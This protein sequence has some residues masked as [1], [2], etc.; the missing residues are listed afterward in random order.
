M[1]KKGNF[2]NSMVSGRIK[3]LGELSKV[4]LMKI[5]KSQI[6]SSWFNVLFTTVVCLVVLL[7]FYMIT[8][9]SNFEND[10]LFFEKQFL[11]VRKDDLNRE[12]SNRIDEINFIIASI[13]TTLDQENQRKI[14]DLEITIKELEHQYANKLNREDFLSMVID[15]IGKHGEHDSD[16]MYFAI[17]MDGTAYL[18]D[19]NKSII[20]S[21]VLDIKDINGK[22]FIQDMI[23]IV[24]TDGEGYLSYY[25]PKEDGDEAFRKSSYFKYIESLDAFIGT[26][27]YYDEIEKLAQEKVYERFQNYY[28]GKQEYIFVVNYDGI[29]KVFGNREIVGKDVSK[30][31]DSGGEYLHDM[32]MEIVRKE[33][34]GYS[35]YTYYERFNNIDKSKKIA[36]VEGLDQW[37]VYIGMGFYLNE[38]YDELELFITEKR[39]ELISNVLVFVGAFIII[40]GIMAF[41]IVRSIEMSKKYFVQE[42]IIYEKLSS[43]TSEAILIIDE[44]GAINYMNPVAKTLM[45]IS[46]EE[47]SSFSIDDFIVKEGNNMKLVGLEGK[48]SVIEIHCDEIRHKNTDYGV[49]F[50]TDITEKHKDKE[51][52]KVIS[53]TDHLTELPNRRKF[54][55]D[56]QEHLDE[57]EH[58]DESLCIALIDL[59]KFKTINDTFGHDVGDKVL[60]NFGELF[61][62]MTRDVDLLYRYGGEE[63][64]VIL[65]K[66]KLK[67]GKA[68]LERINTEVQSY[69]WS[70]EGLHI[71]FTAGLIEINNKSHVKDTNYY[72]KRV[73]QLLY[74]GKNNG[75]RRI[76]IEIG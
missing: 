2:T 44:I 19:A 68:V 39:N 42:E 36:Y 3:V 30:V 51:K 72:F 37:N 71:S 61:N 62:S 11:N 9:V 21:N 48:E 53:I 57:L 46:E 65:P 76:E 28:E 38:F 63:F 12:I 16:N 70:V 50:I 66:T 75:R 35:M 6:K 73:D 33:G 7:M 25:W 27:V 41:Y 74:Q 26:G 5:L 47:E 15:V 52:L 55:D 20:G 4:V 54:I 49:M 32:F 17:G 8:E 34:S 43:L 45:E 23:D 18:S 59:D 14:L 29:A 58:S 69:N 67:E 22:Y 24:K 13:E 31:E 40:G 10:K 60:K 56:F 1:D 64:A